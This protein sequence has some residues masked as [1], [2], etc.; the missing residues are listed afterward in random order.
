MSEVI[1]TVIYLLR[2]PSVHLPIAA[3][4]VF[5]YHAS[6]PASRSNSFIYVD[7][8]C[9]SLSTFNSSFFVFKGR[10]GGLYF[11]ES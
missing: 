1:R 10:H 8:I 4:N 9:D 11:P 7:K 3:G 5:A 2:K 6:F